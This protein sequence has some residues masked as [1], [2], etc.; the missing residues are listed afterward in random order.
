VA[1]LPAE[2][3]IPSLVRMSCGSPALFSMSKSIKDSLDKA[4]KD[5]RDKHLLSFDRNTASR[6]ELEGFPYAERGY[7]L[8]S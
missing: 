8:D 1:M 7:T 6:L 4:S 3:Q 2:R 5:L